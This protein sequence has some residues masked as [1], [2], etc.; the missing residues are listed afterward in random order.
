V[1]P[2]RIRRAWPRRPAAAVI[3][4]VVLAGIVLSADGSINSA[5]SSL[6][7]TF[8]QQRA[9]VDAPFKVFSGTIDYDAAHP[10]ATKAAL[11]VDVGS[12]DLGDADASAELRKPAWFD[13]AHHPIA[14]FQS[15]SVKRGA[16]GRL[17]V[18]GTLEIKGRAQPITVAVSVQSSGAARTFDGSFEL[19][20]KAFG[21]G[22]AQWDG[23]LDDRVRVRFHLLAA[24]G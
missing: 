15:A 20:R 9:P 24:G 1:A 17:E 10:E 16:D 14:S 18:S 3:A 7:A 22:D 5:G 21:I 4:T 12:L 19:S 6:V 13:Y 2:W 23:V 8:T 11:R